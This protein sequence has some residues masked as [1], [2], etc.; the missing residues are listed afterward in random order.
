M[1]YIKINE[2]VTSFV[3]KEVEAYEAGDLLEV[4]EDCL[5]TKIIKGD[6]I[7]ILSEDYPYYNV[8]F[9]CLKKKRFVDINCTSR[10]EGV[11]VKI[12]YNIL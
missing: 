10:L 9:F 2:K 5:H 7:L 1:K 6:K 12:I 3:T 4:L 11:K 8:A